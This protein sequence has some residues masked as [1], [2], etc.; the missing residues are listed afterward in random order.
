MRK[1]SGDRP[2]KIKLLNSNCVPQGIF[3]TCSIP[4]DVSCPLTPVFF[5]RGTQGHSHRYRFTINKPSERSARSCNDSC[6]LRRQAGE[7]ASREAASI[8]SLKAQTG[9]ARALSSGQGVRLPQVLK[10]F[11]LNQTVLFKTTHRVLRSGFHFILHEEQHFS[12]TLTNVVDTVRQT[13]RSKGAIVDS[14]A[15]IKQ[16]DHV[17]VPASLGRKEEKI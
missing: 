5:H 13:P 7:A 14:F 1:T 10:W 8:Q 2:E 15:F 12:S 4:A 11:S 6:H 16:I 3:F 17:A 9:D